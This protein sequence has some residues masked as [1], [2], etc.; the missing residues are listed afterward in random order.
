MFW[1]LIVS[2]KVYIYHLSNSR[3]CNY[4]TRR[5]A[6][7]TQSVRAFALHAECWVFESRPRQTL[8]DK[9]SHGSCVV[10]VP[11]PKTRQQVGMSRLLG[12]YLNT[13]FACGSRC[14]TLKNPHY[15]AVSADH[16]SN[17]TVLHREWWRVHLSEK[18]SRGTESAKQKKNTHKKTRKYRCDLNFAVITM[19]ET[20][21]NPNNIEYH[22]LSQNSKT[23]RKISLKTGNNKNPKYSICS[24]NT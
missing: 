16:R 20:C 7:V 22:F 18:F 12:Y 15:F 3:L 11:M 24:L 8:V 2:V 13:G 14:G 23:V 17:F 1:L 19:W 5:A 10:A 4:Y 21:R 6:V 9:T